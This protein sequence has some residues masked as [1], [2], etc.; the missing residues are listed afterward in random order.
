MAD[1]KFYLSS[2]GLNWVDIEEK[3]SGMHYLKCKGL[4]DKGKPKNKYQEVFADSDELRVY[5][6][7][8]VM[9]ESTDI[10]FTFIFVGDDRQSVYENFYKDIKK[11][12]YYYYDTMRYKK[13]YIT[14]F[15]AVKPSDDIYKGS[16]PYIQADFKFKNLWGECKNVEH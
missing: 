6:P 14:L 5:E 13:A 3:Y 1:I 7:D 12:K 11:G 16:T 2:N 15:E 10:T 9:L 8:N 4:E